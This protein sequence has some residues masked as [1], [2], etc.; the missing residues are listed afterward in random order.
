MTV[1]HCLFAM[2]IDETPIPGAYVI[3]SEPHRDERGLFA[4]SFC[5]TTFERFGLDT[6]IEQ[7]SI[8]TNTRRGTLRGMH[9]QAPPSEEVKLVR[10][11]RGAMYDVII[12]LRPKSPMYCQ[13]FSADLSED[14]HRALYVPK[15]VAH[16]FQSLKDQTHVLYQISTAYDSSSA[17]GV[18]WNDPTFGI[19]WPEPVTIISEKD[20]SFSDFQPSSA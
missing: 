8:S 1:T 7:C 17:R 11:I 12:D 13:W 4:R 6:L 18:R 14:N 10:C 19:G 5:R 2:Q 9:Y 20:R 15:G 3:H 16:G